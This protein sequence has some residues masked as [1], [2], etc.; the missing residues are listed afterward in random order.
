MFVPESYS[1]LNYSDKNIYHLRSSAV[2][3]EDF[4]VR[5]N[6]D[7]KIDRVIGRLTVNYKLEMKGLYDMTTSYSGNC[8]KV[9]NVNKF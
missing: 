5:I 8:S 3:V 1:D 6:T 2:V 7:I 9:N 4:P